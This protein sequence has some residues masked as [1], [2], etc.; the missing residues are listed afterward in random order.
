M[1]IAV[2]VARGGTATRVAEDA[3]ASAALDP[4]EL[5]RVDVHELASTL[6]FVSD[7]L[8]EPDPAKTAHPAP[9]QHC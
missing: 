5:L 3:L 4:A 2:G 1:A 7:R 8:L 9:F 6:A